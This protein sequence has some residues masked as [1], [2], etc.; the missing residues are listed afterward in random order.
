[1]DKVVLHATRR[2]VTGKQ[3]RALRRAGKL[4]GVLYGHNVEPIAITLELRAASRILVGLTGSSLVTLNVDGNESSVLVREKQRNFITNTLLHVD[5]QAV[6]L[7][8]KIRADVNIV[9]QGISPAVK[10]FNGVV[11]EG[12]QRVEVE[13][14]PQYLPERI[15]VDISMLNKIGDGIYIRDL[16]IEGDV[17]ILDNLEE[18]VVIITAPEAEEV[19][20]AVESEVVLEPEVIEKGKKEEE[21]EEEKK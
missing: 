14:L 5:F 7:T 3:V 4:P 12:V 10:D 6:S 1:M 16:K 15:V 11:V 20:V 18:M 19:V 13:C 9:F 2:T 17:A 21:G 8:E